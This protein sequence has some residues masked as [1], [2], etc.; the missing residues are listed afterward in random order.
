[1]NPKLVP[2]NP[3][4]GSQSLESFRPISPA[5]AEATYDHRLNEQSN[6]PLDLEQYL[7]AVYRH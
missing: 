4:P 6:D 5:D 1:M 3:S 2:D 7:G